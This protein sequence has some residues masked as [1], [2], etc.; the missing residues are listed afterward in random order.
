VSEVSS[1]ID[2]LSTIGL[3]VVVGIMAVFVGVYV[4]GSRYNRFLI[5]KF[6]TILKAE[7]GPKCEKSKQQIY[8]T[9]GFRLYCEPKGNV[10]LKNWEV[11]LFLLNRENLVHHIISRF[12]PNYDILLTTANFLA[13]PKLRLE[14]INSV[15]KGITKDDEKV[16][17]DLK[18]VEASKMGKKYIVKAS[19]PDRVEKLF[20]DSEFMSMMNKLGDDFVRITITENP[21][22]LLFSTRARES[23]LITHVRLAE[24]VGNYFKPIKRKPKILE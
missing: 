13:N 9:S 22:H 1:I 12:R 24:R 19:E 11:V 4:W 2:F 7:L 15:S 16:L 5:N 6:G 18:K 23:T 10:P 17:K 8:R 14:I 21:P 20:R 3:F